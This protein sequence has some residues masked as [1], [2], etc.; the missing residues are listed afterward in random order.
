MVQAALKSLKMDYDWDTNTKMG[1]EYK[2]ANVPRYD[3]SGLAS[4]SKKQKL[5]D[6]YEEEM[7]M[8][9]EVKPTTSGEVAGSML[10]IADAGGTT[11]SS[12]SGGQTDQKKLMGKYSYMKSNKG[13]QAG[14]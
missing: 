8:Q 4:F 12:S 5:K 11:D 14:M 3:L 1:E 13:I 6:V 9:T 10:C 7:S 2:K